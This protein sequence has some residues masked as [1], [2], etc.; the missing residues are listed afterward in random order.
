MEDIN[1]IKDWVVALRSGKFQQ[2]TGT[3]CENGKF[4]CLGVLCF[5]NKVEITKDQQP[6]YDFCKEVTGKRPEIFYSYNDE[7]RLSFDRIA[8]EIERMYNL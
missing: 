5:I 1:V 2:T 4:C 7:Q 3:L 8:D 6:A